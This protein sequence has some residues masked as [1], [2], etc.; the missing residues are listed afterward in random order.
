MNHTDNRI[1]QLEQAIGYSFHDKILAAE[2]LQMAAKKTVIAIEGDFHEIRKNADL[3]IVGGCILNTVLATMWF[4]GQDSVGQRLGRG[5]WDKLRNSLISKDSLARHGFEIQL[6][7]LIIGELGLVKISSNM[8][9]LALEAV[10]GAVYMDAKQDGLQAVQNI[11][12]RLK[13]NDHPFL[14]DGSDVW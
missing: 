5:D 9:A 8:V 2:A 3:V 11:V 10:I 13:I 4:N 7:S 6:D 12:K 14:V 1:A